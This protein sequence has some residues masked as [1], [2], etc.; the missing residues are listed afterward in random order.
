MNDRD[1]DNKIKERIELSE[2][3]QENKK[4]PKDLAGVKRGNIMTFEEA[5]GKKPNLKYKDDEIYQINCQTC[6]VAYEARRRG[7]DVEAKGNFKSSLSEMLSRATNK[8]WIDPKTG[9]YPEYI[10]V[11]YF[12]DI[13]TPKKYVKYLENTLKDKTRYTMQFAWKGKRLDGHI[14]HIFKENDT[15]TIYDPQVGK[16]YKDII[17]YLKDVKFTTT[18]Y[19]NK[20]TIAPKLLEVENY[21]FNMDVVNEILVKAGD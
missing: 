4:Y 3:K 14:V 12:S 2:K 7:Y 21:E 20:F 10:G 9:K 16:T 15:I 1:K 18:S 11:D 5:D 8:A 17:K 13:N 19:G 6:V